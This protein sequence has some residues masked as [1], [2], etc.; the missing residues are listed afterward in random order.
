MIERLDDYNHNNCLYNNSDHILIAVSGGIDSMVMLDLLKRSVNNIAIAH[1]NFTLR[2]KE[3]D[4][5][6]LF[7]KAYSKKH[8]L[9]LFSKTF[10]T[11][12][13]AKENKISVQMAARDLRYTW[14]NEL[15]KQHSF[16][17][18]A[19]GHNKNDSIETF[20]INLSRGTG[21]NGLCGIKPRF[22]YVIRPLLFAGRDEI[23]NYANE[24]NIEFREDS[25]NAE[26]KYARNKIRHELIPLL[27][28]INPSI[29]NS[30]HETIDRLEM[31]RQIYAMTIDDIKN[32]LLKIY[33]SGDRV[34]IN[35]NELNKLKPI[36]AYIYEIFSDYGFGRLQVNDLLGILQ[37]ETGK[38]LLSSSHS[39]S[40][41]RDKIIINILSEQRYPDLIINSENEFN[42]IPEIKSVSIHS[43]NNFELLKDS[44][45][46]CL[47][48]DTLS[49]PVLIRYW[50][51]GDYIY[52]LGMKGRKKISDLLI[53]SKIPLYHKKQLRVL[54]SEGNICWLIGIKI[55]ERYKISPDTTRVLILKSD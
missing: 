43:I 45:H 24:N 2:G 35:I 19:V 49:Y 22:G 13:Y 39:V 36:K 26:T 54:E 21:L 48:A 40:R 23:R 12:E 11:K 8:S 7:I 37:A 51:E 44:A 27:S 52:P 5:D 25:S 3:S 20:L 42:T 16:T 28:E 31:T 1:C 18:I 38:H 50:K 29:I 55:G 46:A 47:D 17:K 30:L 14:L 9:K 32:R 10:R 15:T 6:E 4:E 34:E 33:S 41:D 53:D